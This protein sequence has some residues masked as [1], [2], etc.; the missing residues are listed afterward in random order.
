MGVGFIVWV[1]RGAYAG[2]SGT[3]LKEESGRSRLRIQ[4]GRIGW[5]DAADTVR[6]RKHV[7]IGALKRA[8][9]ALAE[10]KAARMAEVRK[11]A[12]EGAKKR[13]R[14]KADEAPARRS[15]WIVS[16]GLPGLGKRA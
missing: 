1:A 14:L 13:K 7:P 11:R 5:V 4:D 3:V 10:L 2:Y 16:G 6:R 12:T 8:E 9:R 15:G